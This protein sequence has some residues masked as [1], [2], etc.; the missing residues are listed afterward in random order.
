MGEF[1]GDRDDDDDGLEQFNVEWY[2]QNNLQLVR[3]ERGEKNHLLIASV[4]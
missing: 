3:H 1:A 2:D 4:L